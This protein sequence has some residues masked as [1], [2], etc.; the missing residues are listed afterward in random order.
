MTLTRR[1]RLSVSP[2]GGRDP[3]SAKPPENHW[4]SLIS[5]VLLSVVFLAVLAS[6][7]IVFETQ[8]KSRLALEHDQLRAIAELKTS[9]I[10]QWRAD[11][12]GTARDMTASPFLGQE[13]QSWFVSHEATAERRIREVIRSVRDNH[14]FEEIIIVDLKGTIRLGLADSRGSLSGE[15]K[16]AYD[17]AIREQKPVMTDLHTATMPLPHVDIVAPLF[18]HKKQPPRPIGALILTLDAARFLY[19]LV[20]SWPIPSSSA[21]T[22]IAR[23]EGERVLYLNDLRF[24]KEAALKFSIPMTRTDNPAVMAALGKHGLV[25][26]R[27]YRGVKVIAVIQRIPDSPW[28]LVAKVDK[29]E[30]FA[31]WRQQALLILGLILGFTAAVLGIGGTVY[32]RRRKTHYREM[33]RAEIERRALIRHFEYLV[34][35]A[36]DI[37]ILVDEHGCVLEANDRALKAYGYPREEMIGLPCHRLIDPSTL[38]A[39]ESRLRIVEKTGSFLGEAVHCRKDGSPFPVET[40]LRSIMIE[41]SRYLQAIIRDISDRKRNEAEIQAAFQEKDALLKEIHHR[42]KNNMQ[43]I[44]SLLSL[45]ARSLS[46]EPAQRALKDMQK[47]VRAMA[48]VHEKLYRSPNL[49]RIDFGDYVRSLVVSLVASQSVRPERIRSR[50]DIQNIA[51]DLQTAVPLALIINELV[52][53]A[54]K[55]A[56][57]D[58]R[59]GEIALELRRREDGR[60]SLTVRDDGA[61]LPAGF[62]AGRAE[63]LGLGIVTMLVAQLDGTLESGNEGGAVFRIVF[64]EAETRQ[65]F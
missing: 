42:V 43:V 58:E 16:D 14:G 56:F 52:S 18:D 41:G 25:E 34:Q 11:R 9:Q 4:R 55:H 21:E 17:R 6:G 2:A 23:R 13:I 22:L 50:V 53:N 60:F 3:E 26:G 31:D 36:N 64:Q 47:R 30:A 65:R 59:E 39:F 40:S 1:S 19:P 10:T 46:D 28:L 48:L 12:L 7:Y 8:R 57:P 35:Y 38:D 44:S 33:F 24:V 20:R 45:Q 63:S 15:V 27:D 62:D 49:S 5:V 61:G 51:F 32:Q 54:V 29:A 37:I